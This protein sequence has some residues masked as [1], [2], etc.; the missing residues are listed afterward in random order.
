MILLAEGSMGGHAA[1]MAEVWLAAGLIAAT[2]ACAGKQIVEW[3]QVWGTAALAPAAAKCRYHAGLATP[4]SCRGIIGCLVV[5]DR[6][7]SLFRQCMLAEGWEAI[8]TADP[9]TP[10][11][12][13]G[14]KTGEPPSVTAEAPL[15]DRVIPPS[16]TALS[17]PAPHTDPVAE[18]FVDRAARVA[19]TARRCGVETAGIDRLVAGYA[20]RRGS[21]GDDAE[22]RYALAQARYAALK[23]RCEAGEEGGSYSDIAALERMAGS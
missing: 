16:G 14:P 7:D 19:V 12:E 9:G 8:D 15:A 6:T 10:P 23:R 17:P 1:R 20:A 18:D 13:A 11:K 3:R 2:G 21:S 5:S 22:A 4:T